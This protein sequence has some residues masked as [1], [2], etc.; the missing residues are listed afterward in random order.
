MTQYI[1]GFKPG[2]NPLYNWKTCL[3]C[4]SCVVTIG[5]SDHRADCPERVAVEAAEFWGSY[6]GGS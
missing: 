3:E 4:G 5:G 1:P 6:G 2:M